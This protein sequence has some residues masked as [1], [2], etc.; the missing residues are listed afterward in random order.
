MSCT[1]CGKATG[2]GALL[3][4]PCRAALK[5]ARQFSVLELPGTP[6]AVTMT[7]LLT[8]ARA[9][10]KPRVVRRPRRRVSKSIAAGVVAVATAAV[11]AFYIGQRLA[12][13]DGAP[14]DAPAMRAIPPLTASPA[15]VESSNPE[16]VSDLAPPVT[17]PRPR[18][19]IAKPPSKPIE[20]P[21]RT[22]AAVPD[23]VASLPSAPPAEPLRAPVPVAAP[24]PAPDRWQAMGD[25]LARCANEGGLSGFLCDQRVRLESCEGYWG[26]VP[27]CPHPSDY[28]R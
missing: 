10:V 11:C 8:K 25:A 20:A 17:P 16:R 6:A 14:G 19:A 26:R 28:P 21:L 9:P 3:C 22:D 7:G 12:R 5:R 18:V 27:Q 13:A 24:A 1:I 4:R 2:P 23:T 15:P